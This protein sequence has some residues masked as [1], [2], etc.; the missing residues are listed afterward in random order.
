MSIIIIDLG[1]T[2]KN[3]RLSG[4]CYDMFRSVVTVVFS[5]CFLCE[6]HQND[7]FF[8]FLKLFLKSEHQN[9]TKQIKFETPK[10]MFLYGHLKA[11]FLLYLF[12]YIFLL[13]IFEDW[14]INKRSFMIKYKNPKLQDWNIKKK[15]FMTKMYVPK[16]TMTKA[17][18]DTPLNNE[19]KCI[20]YWIMS[21]STCTIGVY[22]ETPHCFSFYIY[23]L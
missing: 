6:I 17:Y 15:S 10:F 7:I 9:N 22:H 11:P 13:S 23:N 4:Y 18:S 3:I 5:K 14:N 20:I 2:R 16:T 1:P 12:I 19:K 8:I 21:L